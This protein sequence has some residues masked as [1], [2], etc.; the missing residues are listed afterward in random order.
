MIT[1]K[2]S[3]GAAFIEFLIFAPLFLL[4]TVQ[5]YEVANILYHHAVM[6]ELA[7][8]GARF[9]SIQQATN[10]NIQGLVNVRIQTL[11]TGGVAPTLA[12]RLRLQPA[13]IQTTASIDNDNNIR[14]ELQGN[15]QGWFVPWQNF[16]IRVRAR[17]PKL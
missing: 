2:N 5:M 16:P 12:Q 1:K 3:S 15:F 9:G 13:G 8:E 6:T 14:V 10:N 4:F 7:R 11:Y 17:A